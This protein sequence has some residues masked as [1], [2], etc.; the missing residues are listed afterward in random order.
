M[1]YLENRSHVGQL[2]PAWPFGL[3]GSIAMLNGSIE[4]VLGMA[5]TKLTAKRFGTPRFKPG[6]QFFMA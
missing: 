1:T 4:I 6:W 5:L 2:G 3:Y